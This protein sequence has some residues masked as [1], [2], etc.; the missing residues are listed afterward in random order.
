MLGPDLGAGERAVG[1]VPTLTQLGYAL[2]ILLLAP[3]GD[4]MDRRRIILAKTAALMLALL[5]SGLAP[6]W[7]RC[8]LPAWPWAWPPPWRRTWYRPPPRW[9]PSTSAARW[10]A[11]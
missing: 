4:R 8:W 9:R 7:R 11:R 10:W 5:A 1:F 3:L 2:G 6:A